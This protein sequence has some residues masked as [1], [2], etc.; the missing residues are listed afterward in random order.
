MSNSG[1][2]EKWAA[3]YQKVFASFGATADLTDQK[4]GCDLS[5]GALVVVGATAGNL[6]WTDDLDGVNT[7][8]LLAGQVLDLPFAM[9][10]LGVCTFGG[11]LI[12]YW[13]GNSTDY[14]PRL[15]R[16]SGQ[17]PAA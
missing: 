11:Q 12:V 17:G 15:G 7:L 2:G 13:H 16:S 3:P 1:F 14:G 6:V 4:T 9:K 8:A 10:T 5:S